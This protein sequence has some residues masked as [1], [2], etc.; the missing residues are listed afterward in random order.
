MAK[1]KPAIL[2]DKICPTVKPSGY[3]YGMW[4][5]WRNNTWGQSRELR[6]PGFMLRPSSYPVAWKLPGRASVDPE[7][8]GSRKF[9][10]VNLKNTAYSNSYFI[11]SQAYYVPRPVLSSLERVAR[12]FNSMRKSFFTNGES[13]PQK[14]QITPPTVT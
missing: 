10:R 6:K 14:H 5:R 1:A 2:S 11:Y 13:K 9:C 7:Y 3:R 12:L 4:E 8:S